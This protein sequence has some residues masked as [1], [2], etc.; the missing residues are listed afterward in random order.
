MTKPLSDFTHA[1][2]KRANAA[3]QLARLNPNQRGSGDA[4]RSS[5][6]NPRHMDDLVICPSLGCPLHINEQ[7][8]HRRDFNKH[9]KDCHTQ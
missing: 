4:Y 6:D 1:R 2:A 5:T 8:L 9:W 3:R 7:S